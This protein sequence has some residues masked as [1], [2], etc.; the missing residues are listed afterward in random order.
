MNKDL[1]LVDKTQYEDQLVLRIK[2]KNKTTVLIRTLKK[3]FKSFNN[4]WIKLGKNYKL[5]KINFL[6][7]KMMKDKQDVK[8][9]RNK[10]TDYKKKAC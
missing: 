6:F 7:F 3:K 2:M 9:Q 1:C 5:C 4:K 8:Y 10:K